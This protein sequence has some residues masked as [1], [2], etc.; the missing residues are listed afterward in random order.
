ML[1]KEIA[2]N[3]AK[4]F[5]KDCIISGI[6]IEKAILFG[7]VV[8]ERFNEFSD[9]DIALISSGFSENFVINAR[10]TSKINIKYPL[11]EVHH[12]NTEYFKKGDPFIDEI[13]N[14]GVEIYKFY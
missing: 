12:F 5:I 8:N 1:T 11:I 3:Q 9:I 13:N 2:I 6:N 14:T 7:S 10:M 4:D